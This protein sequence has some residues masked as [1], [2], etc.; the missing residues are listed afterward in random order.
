MSQQCALAAQKANSTLG[1]TLMSGV[2]S[3]EVVV[4][5]YSVLLRPP[6]EYCVQACGPQYRYNAELLEWV[7]RRAL[8]RNQLFAQSD[9]GRTRRNG[10]KFKERD[11]H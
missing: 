7:Q 1:C 6:L 9:S 5:L 3:R 4:P 10:F 2:A 11:L 8:E